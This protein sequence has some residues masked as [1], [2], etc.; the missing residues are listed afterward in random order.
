MIARILCLIIGYVI[1]MV[2]LTSYWYAKKYHKL[3]IR[4]KGSGNAGTTNMGRVLGKK[5]AIVT[6]VGDMCKAFLS[7]L[8]CWFIF[9]GTADSTTIFLYSGLGVVLGHNYPLIF[10]FKGGKGIATSA[11][12]YLSMMVL[13]G[14][15]WELCLIGTLTFLAVLFITRYMSL[16]SLSLSAGFCIEFIIF[17]ALGVLGIGGA[18]LVEADFLI[19]IISILAFIRHKSNIIRLM[20]GT[21]HRMWSKDGLQK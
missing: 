2:C 21:E 12:V 4:T 11:G 17:G 1:G 19:L 13:P 18:V 5:A 3:D 15:Y 10:G 9:R 8:I 14:H 20:N 16:A 7:A 6:L